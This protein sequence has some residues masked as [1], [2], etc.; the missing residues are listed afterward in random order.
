MRPSANARPILYALFLLSGAAGLIYESVWSRYLGLFVGHDAYAQVVVLAIFLGGMSLGAALVSRRAER[1]RN[2]L[3]GYAIMEGLAGLIGFTFHDAYLGITELAYTTLL[4]TLANGPL[5]TVAVWG[6][7]ALRDW[8][9]WGED[10]IHLSSEGH[11]RVALAAL[12]ALGHGTDVA[13][14]ATPLAPATRGARRDEFRE[15]AQWAKTHAAPWVQRRLRGESSG[16]RLA[17]KRPTLTPLR[18]PDLEP[19]HGSLPEG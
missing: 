15:H 14:W 16:D 4:P 19:A 3:L 17:A 10:R 18:D 2:P 11:R 13:E 1:I 12:T 9:M 6:I 7:A 5:R 8:R